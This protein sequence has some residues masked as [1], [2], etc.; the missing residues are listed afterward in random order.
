MLKEDFF[1]GLKADCFAEAVT[2]TQPVAYEMGE[3]QHDFDAR[4]LITAGQIT[5]GVA[6]VSTTYFVGDVFRLAAGTPHHESAG[7]EG[8][9]YLA[10]R[11]KVLA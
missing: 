11:R 3:H 7:P 8:V 4:A 1:A 9:T 2:I 5:L 6:G 10:G